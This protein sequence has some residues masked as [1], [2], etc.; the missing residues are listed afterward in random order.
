MTPNW[1][2]GQ[3]AIIESY[4][5]YVPPFDVAGAVVRL[6]EVVPPQ[7]LAGLQSVVLTNK[8]SLSRERRRT[9]T[10]ARNQKVKLSDVRGLYH[11]GWKGEPAWIEI[12]VDATLK[13]WGTGWRL[14]RSIRHDMAL[15]YVL[16]HEIG[17]HIHATCKPEFKERE[18]AA[19]KWRHKLLTKHVRQRYWWLVFL[20]GPVNVVRLI[21]WGVYR[22]FRLRK[23]R[24]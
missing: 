4:H 18:D 9:T 12:F 16:Y 8:A 11:P 24:E 10:I 15:G 2:A 3:P 1:P 17:H 22:L 20:V 21:W 7:G 14:T 13:T 19:D 23:P 6:M 5:D